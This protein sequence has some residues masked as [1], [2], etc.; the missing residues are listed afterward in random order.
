MVSNPLNNIEW[1][2]ERGCYIIYQRDE[3][4]FDEDIISNFY[5]NLETPV[6]IHYSDGSEKI[7]HGSNGKR[8]TQQISI[9]KNGKLVR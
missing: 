9:I 3:G 6:V 4:E 1:C 8:Y 7:I 5:K 2:N